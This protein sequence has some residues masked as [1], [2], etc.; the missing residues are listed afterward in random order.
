MVNV[1]KMPVSAV[2]R[3]PAPKP[4]P[5]PASVACSI[6]PARSAGPPVV[7]GSMPVVSAAPRR[8]EGDASAQIRSQSN[9]PLGGARGLSPQVLAPQQNE[10]ARPS[11]VPRLQ[12]LEDEKNQEREDEKNE[13]APGVEVAIN[14]HRF[15]CVDVLGRGSYS[16]VWRAM[17]LEATHGPDE[18]ALKE[19]RCSSQAELQQ[20]IFEVQVLLALEKSATSAGEPVPRVPRCITYTV[21]PCDMGWKARTAMTVVPGQSLDVFIRRSPPPGLSR[22]VALG[23]SCALAAQLVIQLGPTLEHLA[24]IAW[25]RDV[26]SHNILVDDVPENPSL[27]QIARASYHLIDFGL[28]VD[29]QSWVTMHGHWKSE[30]IGGDSRYWPPSSWIMHLLGPEGFA[31]RTS[32]CEQYQTRLDIHG[33]G[34]TALELICSAALAA[35]STD[36]LECAE[37]WDAIL[38]SWVQYRDDVWSWWSAVYSVFFEGGDILPVQQQLVEDQ[39]IEKLIVLLQNIRRNMRVCAAQL[40]D[41]RIGLVLRVVADMIDEESEMSLSYA[42]TVMSEVFAKWLASDGAD[43]TGMRRQCRRGSSRR[44]DE[45]CLEPLVPRVSPGQRAPQSAGSA[46]PWSVST[47]AGEVSELVMPVQGQASARMCPIPRDV[48][49]GSAKPRTPVMDARDGIPLASF[50]NSLSPPPLKVPFSMRPVTPIRGSSPVA[51]ATSTSRG[52]MF[53]PSLLQENSLTLSDSQLRQSRSSLGVVGPRQTDAR[54]RYSAVSVPPDGKIPTGRLSSS[55]VMQ[56]SRLGV[57]RVQSVDRVFQQN[58]NNISRGS[59][60]ERPIINVFRSPS[61]D[62]MSSV[63]GGVFRNPSLERSFPGPTRATSM[64]Q[65]LQMHHPH[66]MHRASKSS[67]RVLTSGYQLQSMPP[68]HCVEA[69][70]PSYRSTQGGTHGQFRPMSRESTNEALESGPLRPAAQSPNTAYRQL[71]PDTRPP[72]WATLRSSGSDKFGSPPPASTA[73]SAIVLTPP[74]LKSPRSGLS[75]NCGDVSGASTGSL[76]PIP[77]GAP[78]SAASPSSVSARMPRPARDGGQVVRPL[79]PIRGNLRANGVTVPANVCSGGCAVGLGGEGDK[80]AGPP[81]PMAPRGD[82]CGSVMMPISGIAENVGGIFPLKQSHDA[83]KERVRNLEVNGSSEHESLRERIRSLEES[84]HRLGRESL[85]RA[86]VGME[87]VAEKHALPAQLPPP[88]QRPALQ[89]SFAGMPA[90][91]QPP[92]GAMCGPAGGVMHARNGFVARCSS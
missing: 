31:G 73:D 89:A 85:E 20:A 5:C 3:R 28:A 69:G 24:S 2:S 78:N 83:L 52:Q 12:E 46:V 19:V 22:A 56:G 25:H 80:G 41:D 57:G 58:T 60:T 86:K 79:S 26:N 51:R 65:H 92:Q 36:N 11:A 59:S 21:E 45:E 55:G 91:A 72:M 48:S 18:V 64:D 74:S 17:V 33:L 70:A 32:L 71:V 27:H 16:E 10:A 75:R 50:P 49:P 44:F 39:V 42:K 76:W 35:S 61:M 82:N 54:R 7:S 63:T 13:Y 47:T 66:H 4:V 40:E 29:S 8:T 67:V 1:Q 81:Y 87:R 88:Q 68:P 90:Q 30:D 34:I 23:R 9:T 14:D 84:L 37:A 15:E 53:S 77:A 62:R 6:P 38:Q 43:T